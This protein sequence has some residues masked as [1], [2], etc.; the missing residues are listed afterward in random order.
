VRLAQRLHLLSMEQREYFAGQ[1]LEIGK[2]MGV[3]QSNR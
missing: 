3:I 1:S 2:M